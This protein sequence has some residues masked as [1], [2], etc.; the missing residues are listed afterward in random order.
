[1][2]EAVL[3]NPR[4]I[5]LLEHFNIYVP[6]YEKTIADI[7]NEKH[8]DTKLFIAFANLYNG[9][10]YTSPVH[11]NFDQVNQI[12]RF[13]KNSH[14]YYTAEIYPDISSII[15][16]MYTSNG[17][18]EI[19][20]VEE[21]FNEYFHEVMEHLNYEDEI[22][23][24]YMT[25]LYEHIEKDMPFTES[26][27]Y[28]V[29][30]YKDH[31]NDIEEKLA[32]LKNLLVKYLPPTNDQQKRRRLYLSLHE[33]EYDLNIHAIIEDMILIPLVERMEQSVKQPG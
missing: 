27:K 22:A 18:K 31:H 32:D 30:D 15:R 14:T 17:Q 16:E 1:M 20:M 12:I 28:S 11:F 5:L 2:A 19:S 25:S 7:C 9:V 6:L 29:K 8:I 10:E 4:I 23:F 3:S 24:P 33:L 26:T 13:L 21:F